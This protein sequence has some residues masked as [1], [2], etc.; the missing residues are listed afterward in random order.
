VEVEVLLEP[1]ALGRAG[2]L[3]VDPAELAEL[4]GLDARLRRRFE[5]CGVDP[6]AGGAPEAW[7]RQA[8]HPV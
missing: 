3:D 1:D 8:R 4:Y 7:L 5:T 2:T 6:R